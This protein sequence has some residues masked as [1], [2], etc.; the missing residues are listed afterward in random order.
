MHDI[1]FI[2]DEFDAFKA[3]M[4]RRH[5]SAEQ[6]GQI[7]SLL[8][9]DADLRA[10][11]TAKQEA[12]AARNAASKQIGQAKAQKDEAR[13]S[14]LMAEVAQHKQKIEEAGAKEGE[15]QTQRDDILA[16]LP[17]I[18]ADDVPDGEDEHGNVEVR[19]WGEGAASG[20]DH[21]DIGEALGLMDFEGAARMSGARFVALK[22]ALARLERNSPNCASAG[23]SSSSTS[24]GRPWTN[25]SNS[26]A[27]CPTPKACTHSS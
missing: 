14:A 6:R 22:G 12:E 11:L 16:S 21:V 9:L 23:R 25:T 17:N 18:A 7:E 10:A 1:K 19:R 5:V 20:K 3:A 13:A 26:P 15:L 2:R 8:G 4:A 27:S 24:A